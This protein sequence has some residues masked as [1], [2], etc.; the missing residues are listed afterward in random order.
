MDRTA[1]AFSLLEL[2]RNPKVQTHLR[3]EIMNNGTALTYADLQSSKLPYLDAVCK[4]MYVACAIVVSLGL[5]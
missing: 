5:S 4:E 1:L 2:A 3:E